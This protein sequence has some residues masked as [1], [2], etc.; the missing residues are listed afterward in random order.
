MGREGS[1]KPKHWRAER[2]CSLAWTQHWK[3]KTHYTEIDIYISHI[4]IYVCLHTYVYTHTHIFMWWWLSSQW[5]LGNEAVPW[6]RP[7]GHDATQLK[8]PQCS[9]REGSN[10]PGVFA[11]IPSGGGQRTQNSDNS[12]HWAFIWRTGVCHRNYPQSRSVRECP[13]IR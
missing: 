12:A 7:Q 3:K 8:S 11:N 1:P 5:G 13:C 9:L 2:E 4:C 10:M 6:S